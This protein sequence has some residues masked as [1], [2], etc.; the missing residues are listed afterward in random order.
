MPPVL[1]IYL[2]FPLRGYILHYIIPLISDNNGDNTT[3]Q[4][5]KQLNPTSTP[6]LCFNHS[7][8]RN[9]ATR[10]AV[11][12]NKRTKIPQLKKLNSKQKPQE[13]GRSSTAPKD[14]HRSEFTSD[15]S[16][17]RRLK[18]ELGRDQRQRCQSL[19]LPALMV[20]ETGQPGGSPWSTPGHSQS[21]SAATAT[22]ASSALQ[23]PTQKSIS[24]CQHLLPPIWGTP[25]QRR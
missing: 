5:L 11:H 16:P 6:T 24:C 15:S 23:L 18:D 22:A 9:C 10:R 7:I 12:L 21:P 3:C 8:K 4:N 14:N 20:L 25:A 13:V 2:I 17:E 19:P 1:Y